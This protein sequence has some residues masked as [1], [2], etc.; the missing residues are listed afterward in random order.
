MRPFHHRVPLPM[1]SSLTSAPQLPTAPSA[2]PAGAATSR[3]VSIDALRGLV[4]VFMLLDHVRETF[5]MHHQVTDP[6]ALA[7]TPPALFFSRVLAHLC[8]PV[9][10]FLAG[11]S[12]FLYGSRQPDGRRAAAVFL[13]QRGLFLVVLELTVVNF[14]WTF[15][16]VRTEAGKIS[17]R[18]RTCDDVAEIEHL[19]AI[20][21]ATRSS[22]DGSRKRR[23]FI[24]FKQCKR[25]V[26]GSQRLG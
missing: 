26:C 16:W 17:D 11:L 8:A 13:V 4:I 12:A 6:M 2:V 18:M 19:H 20:Q 7:D 10:I 3:L 9:F 25:L 24:P 15:Q 14:A 21:P 22:S 1:P 23:A 5:F